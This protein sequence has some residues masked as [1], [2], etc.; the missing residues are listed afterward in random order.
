M[1][2]KNTK[3]VAIFLPKEVADGLEQV[4]T[5]LNKISKIKVTKSTFMAGLFLSWIDETY[6]KAIDIEAK[7]ENKDA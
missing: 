7:E 1:I 2:G 6:H 5:E 4:V 3:K